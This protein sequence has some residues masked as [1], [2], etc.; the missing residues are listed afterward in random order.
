MAIRNIFCSKVK[1]IASN[2]VVKTY[3]G[4]NRDS[5]QCG[6]W[7]YNNCRDCDSDKLAAEELKEESNG[8]QELHED[9]YESGKVFADEIQKLHKSK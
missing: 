3:N 2:G 5:A 1:A 4:S 8:P 7:I 9:D 6:E